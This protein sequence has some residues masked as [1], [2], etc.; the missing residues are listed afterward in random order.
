MAKR[1]AGADAEGVRDLSSVSQGDELSANPKK[2]VKPQYLL[3][4]VFTDVRLCD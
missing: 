4:F 1:S 2:P 3:G